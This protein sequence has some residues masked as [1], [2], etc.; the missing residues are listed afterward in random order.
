MLVYSFYKK[1]LKIV[2]LTIFFKNCN[3]KEHKPNKSKKENHL[4]K[5]KKL[6]IINVYLHV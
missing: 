2:N 4:K 1:I 6:N 3:Q 5:E